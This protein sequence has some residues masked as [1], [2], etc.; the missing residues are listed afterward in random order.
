VSTWSASHQYLDE[1]AGSGPSG[2]T[3]S[4]Q[5]RVQD[6]TPDLLAGSNSGNSVLRYDGTTGAFKGTFVASGSGGLGGPSGL[7]VGPDGDLY[8]NG[9][10]PT[11]NP[12]LH[13]DGATGAFLGTLVPSGGLTTSEGMIFG[14]DGNLY[15]VD[16]TGSRIL[17]YSGTT[18][19]PLPA[20]GQS[21]AI[22]VAAHSGGLGQPTS[23][24]FGADG[25]LDVTDFVSS[26]ALR[27]QGPAG[28]SPRP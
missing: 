10:Q 8:V 24:T 20:P 21:G 23:L 11:N 18:G 25:N 2:G 9:D 19:A 17:R 28:A 3:Y 14:P 1:P 22:Y 5:V 27:Y 26:S 6:N 13:Y 16:E 15:R 7:A 4:A 12:V